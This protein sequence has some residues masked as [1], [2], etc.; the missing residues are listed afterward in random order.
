MASKNWYETMAANDCLEGHDT[1]NNM[2]SI[3]SAGVH[4]QCADY[5]IYKDGATTYALNGTTGIL[6]YSGTNTVTV[7]QSAMDLYMLKVMSILFLTHLK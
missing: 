6:D 3:I 5:I 7:I 2:T 1:W 4:G